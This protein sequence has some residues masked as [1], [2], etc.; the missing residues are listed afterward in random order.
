MRDDRRRGGTREKPNDD[1]TQASVNEKTFVTAGVIGW[2]VAQSR[3]PMLHGAWLRHYGIAGAYLPLPV[4]PGRLEAA[5]RGLAALGFAGAN[6]T[7]PHKAE[8]AARVDRLDATARRMG[9][10]NLVVVAADGTLEGRNTDGFGFMENLREQAPG[11]E[12]AAGP[13]VILGGGGGARAAAASLL[14]AGAPEIRLVNRT[15]AHGARIAAELGGNIIPLG[16]P[17]RSAALAGAGLLVNTTS[18]GMTGQEPLEIR[19]DDLP[20]TAAV[21]DIVYNPLLTPLLLAAGA[22]GH[23]CVPGLGMLLHQARPSFAAW[24]GVLPEITPALRRA[25]EASLG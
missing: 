5:L 17:A 21:C 24:F 19:L 11:W 18:L 8:A 4:R 20:V 3:S 6:V 1:M 22:R 14:E 10:V 23:P 2:P 15:A 13:A 7:V 12:A 25:V 16:W 9:A